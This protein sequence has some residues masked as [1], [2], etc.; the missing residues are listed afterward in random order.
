VFAGR[1]SIRWAV[2]TLPATRS[3]PSSRIVSNQLWINVMTAPS[4]GSES[5][6]EFCEVCG[7]TLDDHGQD[8][9][10][11]AAPYPCRTVCLNCGFM[12]RHVCKVC[13]HCSK[14]IT[15]NTILH[16]HWFVAVAW[17]TFIVCIYYVGSQLLTDDPETVRRIRWIVGIGGLMG[18]I[19][20]FRLWKLNV[21]SKRDNRKSEEML[22]AIRANMRETLERGDNPMAEPDSN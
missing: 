1:S 14:F 3:I 5:R 6:P 13:P 22:A 12:S 16:N 8:C 21:V 15:H 20:I 11:C 17:P 18:A 7:T 9:P 4:D 19:H 10:E 2:P